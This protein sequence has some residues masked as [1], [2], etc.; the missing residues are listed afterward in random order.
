MS[1]VDAEALEAN[2]LAWRGAGGVVRKVFDA[3]L[4]YTDAAPSG[5]GGIE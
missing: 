3:E 5:F 4:E 2:A 1:A